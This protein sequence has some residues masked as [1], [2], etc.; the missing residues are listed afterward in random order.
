MKLKLQHRIAQSADRLNAAELGIE[1]E[2][3]RRLQLTGGYGVVSLDGSDVDNDTAPCALRISYD[4]QTFDVLPGTVVFPNGEYVEVATGEISG[5]SIGSAT[6]TQ[7]VRLE[8]GEAADADP[9]VNPYFNFSTS[10]SIRKKTAREMLIIEPSTVYPGLSPDVQN[11]S[12]VLGSI[13]TDGSVLVADNTRDSL[14]FSRPWFTP[15][16]AQ[17]RSLVG[18]GTPSPTN[19][20]GTSPNDLSVRGYGL[21]QVLGGP[22][23]A[24]IARSTTVGRV[25]G[26]LCSETVPA[27]LFSTDTTGQVTG[28][29]GAFYAPLGFWPEALLKVSLTSS[30][31]ELAAWIPRGRNI[32]AI[33]DSSFPA[34]AS[35][36]V[37]YT[38]VDAGALPGSLAGNVV[39]DMTQ[40]NENELLVAGGSILTEL[41][42]SQVHFSD[43]GLIPMAFDILVGSDGKVYKRP[44][45]LVCNT[46]LDTIGSGVTALTSQPRTP[47]RL[48]FAVSNYISV[49]TEIRFQVTGVDE[50]GAS[51]TEQIVFTG[52]LPAVGTAY[53]EITGQR[54]LTQNKYASA[55]FQV[56]VRNGDGPN[57]TVTVFGEHVPDTVDISDDLLLA[58]VHWSGVEVTANYLN[59]SGVA[60]DRRNVSRGGGKRGLLPVETSLIDAAIAGAGV[61]TDG[62]DETSHVTIVEDFASP[63]WVSL[64]TNLPSNSAGARL[65]YASRKVP[66]GVSFP[67]SVM[68]LRLIPN[69]NVGISSIRDLSIRVT[70]FYNGGQTVYDSVNTA[71]WATTPTPPYHVRMNLTSGSA[72]QSFFAAR[73]EVTS[74]SN[75]PVAEVIQGFILHARGFEGTEDDGLGIGE[76]L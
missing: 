6:D 18:S 22:P 27:G 54:V 2:L 57:T 32:V 66:F 68:F 45:V 12:I 23:S 74:T 31:V 20:H 70:L 8:Y 67:P 16:D 5:V 14:S 64:D 7:I 56:T 65:N 76:D 47:T 75:L 17:H 71:R 51:V 10:P 37:S 50:T 36:E 11:R 53:S 41:S 44:D 38:K 13:S 48:R 62:F 25:A 49:L 26:T 28:V 21:W 61:F 9:E 55:S 42:E 39:I 69:G 40:P 46:K 29:V 58:T 43:V 63:H 33:R 72:T 52:P 60:L 34:A 4:G 1:E 30:G 3:R 19:P 35:V 24:V 73:V 59:G 15:T